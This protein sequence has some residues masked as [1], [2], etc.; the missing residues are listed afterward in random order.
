MLWIRSALRTETAGRN[1]ALTTAKDWRGGPRVGSTGPNA[2]ALTAFPTT[3]TTIVS[4]NQ[5]FARQDSA[6]RCREVDLPTAV[7]AEPTV[8]TTH[9]RPAIGSVPRFGRPASMSS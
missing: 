9:R 5:L 4:G 6:A 8:S 2:P 7:R 3:K 1:D